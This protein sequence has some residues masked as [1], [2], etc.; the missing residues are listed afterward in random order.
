M[1]RVSL[2]WGTKRNVST[3]PGSQWQDAPYRLGQRFN[4]SFQTNKY[5]VEPSECTHPMAILVDRTSPNLVDPADTRP[6][7]VLPTFYGI[8]I[9]QV[10]IGLADGYKEIVT[11]SKL[12]GLYPRVDED[13]PL[14]DVVKSGPAEPFVSRFQNLHP[15]PDRSGQRH[16]SRQGRLRLRKGRSEILA[17]KSASLSACKSVGWIPR[18]GCL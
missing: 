9:Q 2:K 5:I 14:R 18:Y 1:R 8:D 15:A 11:L 4:T 7:T 10:L 12:D 17:C 3:A 16:W 6:A 13:D